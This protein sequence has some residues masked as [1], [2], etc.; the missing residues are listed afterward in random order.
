[1][2]AE[3]F[4]W[5]VLPAALLFIYICLLALDFSKCSLLLVIIIMFCYLLTFGGTVGQ[6]EG[7]ERERERAAGE[8]LLRNVGLG[9]CV[10]ARG[11]FARIPSRE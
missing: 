6:W 5:C 3:F 1:M 2:M 10:A 4:Y 11:T 7:R 8:Y 9:V